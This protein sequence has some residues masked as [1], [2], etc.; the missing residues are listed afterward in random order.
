MQDSGAR[1]DRE[2]PAR[3]AGSALGAVEVAAVADF[4][5]TRE[6]HVSVARIVRH[7]GV[8]HERVTALLRRR[9]G[10]AGSSAAGQGLRRA[11]AVTPDGG[12]G[13][14]TEDAGVGGGKPA[15]RRPDPGAGCPDCGGAMALEGGCRFCPRCGWSR[16]P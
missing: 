6:G 3:T 9:G 5:A 4:L 11:P 12:T 15:D 1:R 13:P 8:P 16:C 2:T 10:R 14:G 7:T